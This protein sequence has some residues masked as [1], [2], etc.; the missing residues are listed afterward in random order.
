MGGRDHHQT[1]C[2]G[3]LDKRPAGGQATHTGLCPQPSGY[4]FKKHK[5]TLKSQYLVSLA[6]PSFTIP[7]ASLTEHVMDQHSGP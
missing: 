5:I 4:D 6:V 3:E 2:E 1:N 7:R